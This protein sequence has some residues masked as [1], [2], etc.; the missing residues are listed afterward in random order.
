MNDEDMI[1]RVEQYMDDNHMLDRHMHV[2]V[3][4]SGG[5][6]SMCLLFVLMRQAKKHF[7]ELTAVHINH[8]IRGAAADEDQAFVESFCQS[9]GIECVCF[10]GDIPALA[11]QAHLSE[12]EAGRRFRYDCFEQVLQQKGAARIAVAHHKN[13]VAETVLM[14]LFRGTGLKGLGGIAPVRGKIIRPLLCLDR[15]EIESILKAQG[16]DWC[17][18]ATNMETD[19]TRNR[20]RHHI[21]SYASENINA[22]AVD[23]ISSLAA[24]VRDVWAYM[25]RQVQRAWQSSLVRPKIAPESWREMDRQWDWALDISALRQ[26][27][28]VISGAVVR[29]QVGHM[30]G[31]LKDISR[32]HVEQVL[33]LMDHQVG[34]RV[35]LPYGIEVVRTYETLKFERKLKHAGEPGNK[36]TAGGP[37][38]DL[39][40]LCEKNNGQLDYIEPESGLQLELR[41]KKRTEIERIEQKQYTKWFDYDKIKNGLNLRHRRTGDFLEINSKGQTKPVRRLMIDA[42]VPE[43]ERE[44]MWIIADGDHAV[45]IMG[46]RISEAYKIT[47][48]TTKIVEIKVKGEKADGR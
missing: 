13:D 3:G 29:T 12:E 28:P 41:L 4:V 2:I 22:G 1:K 18:D 24:S 17:T 10:C 11:R 46:L 21:L 42:K 15:E 20:V 40:L 48:Q 30:A 33:A 36:T 7:I 23:H 8:G 26:M 37:G 47:G 25:D 38:P 43:A 19:Y 34:R 6:D 45:W 14:N 27:D 39:L 35:C 44:K 32:I 16:I 9:H 31:G 5:A